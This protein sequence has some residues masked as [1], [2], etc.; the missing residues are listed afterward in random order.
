MP[1]PT[2]VSVVVNGSPANVSAEEIPLVA[3]PAEAIAALVAPTPLIIAKSGTPATTP[4]IPVSD[5]NVSSTQ[6]GTDVAR[7]SDSSEAKA[8]EKPVA[9]TSPTTPAP[10]EKKPTQKRSGEW[11]LTPLERRRVIVV[12]GP[13][14][15]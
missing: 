14:S 4:T 7:P 15:I 2:V 8:A 13:P 5:S 11:K 10:D 6:T 9:A 3:G 1:S 12:D